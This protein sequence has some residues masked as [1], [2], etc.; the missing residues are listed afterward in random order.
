MYP[1]LSLYHAAASAK[2]S[3][4]L[5]TLTCLKY[6]R[7]PRHYHAHRAGFAAQHKQVTQVKTA[8]VSLGLDGPPGH[9]HA[10]IFF[11][12][13][14]WTRGWISVPAYFPLPQTKRSAGILQV[15]DPPT[16]HP[17]VFILV[18]LITGHFAD[19]WHH[20]T[21]TN[22]LTFF[23]EASDF[24]DIFLNFLCKWFKTCNNSN[25]KRNEIRFF[26]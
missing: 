5:E 11:I 24:L 23:F 12:L 25:K 16:P 3:E 4:S 1:R 17:A 21:H 26:F 7:S 2:I 14:T 6:A 20:P 8:T 13:A 10:L 9:I 15:A 22:T 19:R 18:L